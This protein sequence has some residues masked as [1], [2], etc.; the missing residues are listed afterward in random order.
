MS[1]GAAAKSRQPRWVLRMLPA[2]AAAVVLNLLLLSS[3]ALLSRDRLLPQDMTDPV[4]VRLVS[5][6]PPAPPTEEKRTPPPPPKPKPKPDF[7]PEVLPPAIGAPVLADLTVALD[8]SLFA[9]GPA[10]G[11][12]IFNASDLDQPPVAV[13]NT[14]PIYP[15]KARQ[16]DIQGYVTIKFLVGLDGSVSRAEVLD[17]RP[18][19]LFEQA[20]LK[21]VPGWKFRPGQID[22]Q[23]VP[24]W[25]EKTVR[26]ELDN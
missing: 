19:D 17:S 24:T 2:L 6:K 5:L 21:V 9:G 15:F 23:P 8:S 22:G 11:E 25:V 12:F 14:A 18:K 7:Q 26:F 20:L 13:V 3:A 4:A 10:R 16:R 1:S